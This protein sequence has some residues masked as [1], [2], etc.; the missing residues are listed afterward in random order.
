ML[1]SY[2]KNISKKFARNEKRVLLNYDKYLIDRSYQLFRGAL[3]SDKTLQL[4]KQ[5]LWHFCNFIKM[6]TKNIT[7][8]YVEG[9]INRVIQLQHILQ[10]YALFIQA[11]ITSE[12]ITTASA[13][14]MIPPVRL[15]CEMNDIIL[16][17]RKINKLLPHDNGNATDEAYTREQIKKMLEHSDLRARIPI[18]YGIKWNEIA[19]FCWP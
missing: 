3:H 8:R 1:S 13:H 9:N 15:F 2:G 7:S 18:L 17:W 16:N 12:Q 6:I 4:Y 10:D 11:K 19:Q 5:Q 14:S